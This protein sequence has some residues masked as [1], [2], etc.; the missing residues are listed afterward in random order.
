M[1]SQKVLVWG[2]VFITNYYLCRKNIK[3]KQK[4]IKYIIFI[5][6]LPFSIY[7]ILFHMRSRESND[8]SQILKGKAR[9]YECFAV[10]RL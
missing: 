8:N 6:L 2:M 7:P 1:L 9:E 5:F 10:F 4:R 3:T